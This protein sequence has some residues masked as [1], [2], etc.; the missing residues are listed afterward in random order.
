M[1]ESKIPSFKV[2]F[3]GPANVGKTSLLVRL[4]KD[5][6][7]PATIAPT[8]SMQCFPHNY[9][10][11]T[12]K[13]IQVNFW[14]TAGQERFKGLGSLYYQNSQL[15]IAVFDLTQP[16]SFK[17]V[18][19]YIDKFNEYSANGQGNIILAANKHDLAEDVDITSFIEYAD[20]KGYSLFL[21]SAKTKEGIEDLRLNIID[22]L[23]SFKQEAYKEE[24]VAMG[25]K[26]D[27]ID[28]TISDSKPKE[29]KCC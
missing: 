17:D 18:I 16:E 28:I 25:Q 6:F 14:D 5:Q 22:R 15:C 24:Q 4:D 20:G 2:T 26:D 13:E 11:S 3:V 27:G 9:T 12:G 19:D 8:A 7:N 29:K 10:T 23:D 1:A 21:T